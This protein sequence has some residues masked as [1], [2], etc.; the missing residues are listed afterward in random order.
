MHIVNVPVNRNACRYQRVLADSSDVLQHAC[1][2]ICDRV[3][4]DEM[5]GSVAT[6]V[7]RVCSRFAIEL[8]RPEIVVEQIGDD[9]GRSIQTGHEET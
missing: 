5:P 6:S 1:R 9:G 8:G 2:L 4:F 7:L 3:P